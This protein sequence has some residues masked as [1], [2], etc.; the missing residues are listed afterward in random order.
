MALDS[1]LGMVD[2]A[3][4]TLYFGSVLVQSHLLCEAACS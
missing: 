2:V 4:T 1:P 3:R